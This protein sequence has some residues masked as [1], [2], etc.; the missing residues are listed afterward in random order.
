MG[1]P[2]AS[3]RMDRDGATACVRATCTA[4][5]DRAGSFHVSTLPETRREPHFS[6]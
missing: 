3:R 6:V 4:H 2:E 1:N 5:G